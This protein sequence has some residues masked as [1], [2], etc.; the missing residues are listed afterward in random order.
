VTKDTD[1]A[2]DSF[3]PAHARRDVRQCKRR[4]RGVVGY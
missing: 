2:A 4:T 3:E 1:L